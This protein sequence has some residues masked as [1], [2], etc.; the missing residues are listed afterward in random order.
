MVIGDDDVELRE[1][2]ESRRWCCG[3]MNFFSKISTPL[4]LYSTPE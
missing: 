4:S 2:E 1:R 3:L